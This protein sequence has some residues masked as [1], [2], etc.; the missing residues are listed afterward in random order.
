MLCTRL[1]TNR[2]TQLDDIL[3]KHAP[4]QPLQPLTFKV[5]AEQ[6][7]YHRVLRLLQ[8]MQ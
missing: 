7:F 8:V 2:C 5:S 6:K 1:L 4:R 3:R